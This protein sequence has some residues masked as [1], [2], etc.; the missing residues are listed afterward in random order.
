MNSFRLLA[1]APLMVACASLPA[2]VP[3]RGATVLLVEQT[4]GVLVYL[5]TWTEP[6]GHDSQATV[7]MPKDEAAGPGIVY[8][9]LY[10]PGG[11]MT[12]FHDE[13]VEAAALGVRSVLING[14]VPWDE[15]F[16]GDAGDQARVD[17]Q[18]AH[19]RRAVD[20]LVRL[21]GVD[22][23]RLGY[24]GHDYGA[25]YGALLSGETTNITRFV[26]IAPA[27]EWQTWISYFQHYRDKLTGYSATMAD[28]DPLSKVKAKPDVARLIQFARTDQFLTT[29]DQQKWAS[30]GSAATI[31]TFDS[32]HNHA[33]AD[34][35]AARQRWL[36]E[37]WGLPPAPN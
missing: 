11:D 33:A 30:V 21:P 4:A 18:L 26:L 28:R 10:G 16:E 32:T 25:M 24:V 6:N 9:H 27:P 20:L 3:G 15:R 31:M 37:P 22:P 5:V 8:F 13:A 36:Y 29:E 7:V 34:G 35:K 2:P 1:L 12:E 23:A 14:E 17:R 19:V